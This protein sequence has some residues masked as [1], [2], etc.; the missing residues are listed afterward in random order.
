MVDVAQLRIALAHV[1]H[2]PVLQSERHH[3]VLHPRN[4]GGLA[5]DEA[6]P[7]VVLSPAN[8]IS[9]AKL[10][11]VRP[12]D[13]D[14]ARFRS[15][16]SG[17]PGH[18]LAVLSGEIHDPIAVVDTADA[19]FI[20]LFHAEALVGPVEAHHV[21]RRIVLGQR[22]LGS[23]IPE[24]DQAF[25][26]KRRPLDHT[27][28]GQLLPDDAVDLDAQ[29]MA[30]RHQPGPL[31]LLGRKLQPPRGRRAREIVRLH[32]RDIAPELLECRLDVAREARLDRR[33]QIGVALAHDL[34]HH[35]RLH[36]RLLQLREWLA[37]IDRIEPFGVPHQHHAGHA[38]HLRDLEQVAGLDGRGKRAFIDHQCGLLEGRPQLAFALVGEPP[39]RNADVQ[40]GVT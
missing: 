38:K 12:I 32:F 24:R 19:Q 7:L 30:R 6:E 17:L 36:A 22:Q 16:A 18:G 37:G 3:V 4:F 35:R 25:I 34:A 27:L 10:D 26:G 8:T 33:L 23:R 21:A 13:L 31:A 29:R 14:T 20:T 1:E 28:A 2:P 39:L 5:V 9:F 40:T 15:E 11:R